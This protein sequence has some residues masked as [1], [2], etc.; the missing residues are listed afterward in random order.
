MISKH[1]DCNNRGGACSSCR[2]TDY[3]EYGTTLPDYSFAFDS[4]DEP[5]PN[6]KHLRWSDNLPPPSIGA[7]TR[8]PG[9]LGEGQVVGYFSEHGYLGVLIRLDAPPKW[10]VE[11]NGATTPCH[12]YGAELRRARRKVT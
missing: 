3:F 5:V 12:I 11:Q 8:A 4:E 6:P 10:F 7:K 9:D 2:D 1:R